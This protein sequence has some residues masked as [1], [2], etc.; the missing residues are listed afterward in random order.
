[1]ERI[2]SK[3]V[4]HFSSKSAQEKNLWKSIKYYINYFI[5][6]EITRQGIL[7]FVKEEIGHYDKSEATIDTI[8]RQLTALGYLR[9]LESGT[10]FVNKEISEDMTSSKLRKLYDKKSNW[11]ELE[12]KS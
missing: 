2:Q 6:K 1:M 12:I 11:V 4:D 5:N 3:H 9:H 8:R 10:Y 7:F